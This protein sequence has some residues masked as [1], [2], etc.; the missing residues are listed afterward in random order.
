MP[1]L[2]TV[3]TMNSITEASFLC[4]PTLFPLSPYALY[5]CPFAKYSKHTV[6]KYLNFKLEKGNKTTILPVK[7]RR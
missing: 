6:L 1:L 2:F 4:I 3:F 7:K 5:N